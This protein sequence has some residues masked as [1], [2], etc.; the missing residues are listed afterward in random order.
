MAAAAA[1]GQK[2]TPH[3][4]GDD[5]GGELYW[6]CAGRWSI[7]LPPPPNHS[8]S[9]LPRLVFAAVATDVTPSPYHHHHLNL[10]LPPSPRNNNP[11]QYMAMIA[12]CRPCWLHCQHFISPTRAALKLNPEHIRLNDL[13]NTTTLTPGLTAG[14]SPEYVFIEM[15]DRVANSDG[16]QSG[17][18]NWFASSGQW[19]LNMELTS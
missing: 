3:D 15:T 9:P 18:Q 10:L 4:D 17:R 11:F 7:T 8:P 2:R 6:E 1:A 5:G 19:M 14:S 13:F 16:M 12:S